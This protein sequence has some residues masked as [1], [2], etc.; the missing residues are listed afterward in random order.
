MFFSGIPLAIS[1][2]LIFAIPESMNATAQYAWFFIFYTCANALFYT[3][4]NISYAT[5]SA[6]ITKNDSERVSLGSF[7]YIFAVIASIVVN[8][9]TVSIVDALG[10]GASAWRTVAIVYAAIF[11]V[12]NSLASLVCKELPITEEKA[13]NTSTQKQSDNEKVTFWKLLKVVLTNKYYLLLLAIYLFFYTNS[14]L[15]TSIGVYYFQ[16]IMGNAS[17][18]GVVSLS[19]IV[20]VVGLVFN[21][22]LVKKFG[23]YKVNLVSYIISCVFSLFLMIFAFMGNFLGIVVSIFLRGISTAFL[24]GSLNALVAEVAENNLLRHGVHT[25]GMMFS[26]S[27]IGMK[28]GGGLGAGLAGW[29]LGAAGFDGTVA[30]QPDNVLFMIKFIYGAIPMILTAFIAICLVFMKVGAE[31]KRLKEKLASEEI[32][33]PRA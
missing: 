31:N 16:Y 5:M 12:F 4:N 8:A 28:V 13:T 32:S 20:M 6:L 25:E 17:L 26:C 18:L 24:M 3:A 30:V 14:N 21:P 22:A 7:R 10:G 19:S 1:L 11:F 33:A 2:I 27:S 29:L 15:A 9:I 23:M